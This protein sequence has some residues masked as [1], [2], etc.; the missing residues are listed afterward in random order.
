MRNRR[1]PQALIILDGFGIAPPGPYNAISSAQMPHMHE[2]LTYASPLAA[3]G[4]AVG[5]LDTMPG[6]SVINF[7]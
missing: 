6:G 4:K 7:V 3:S 5:L 1:P 2:W